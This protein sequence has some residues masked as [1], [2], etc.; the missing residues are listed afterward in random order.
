[1]P[2]G[3]FYA[4]PALPRMVDMSSTELAEFLLEKAGVVVTPGIAFGCDD[5]IRISYAP[6][7]SLPE[8][9]EGLERIDKALGLDKEA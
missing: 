6:V 5:R 1:M 7:S 8:L 3:A 9:K 4:F 2:H